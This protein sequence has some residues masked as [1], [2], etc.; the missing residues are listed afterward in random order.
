MINSR[1][2]AAI[3]FVLQAC[4]LSGQT[5]SVNLKYIREFP[6]CFRISEPCSIVTE[7]ARKII[8]DPPCF[9][10]CIYTNTREYLLFLFAPAKYLD[11]LRQCR[12]NQGNIYEAVEMYNRENSV[13]LR[14]ISDR[15]LEMRQSPLIPEYLRYPL[16][17]VLPKCRYESCGD[18]SRGTLE[19]F[20]VYHGSAPE[21]KE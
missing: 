9:R 18:I 12:L 21:T 19:I 11:Q 7:R 3:F 6:E 10:L 5:D 16:P 20:C 17:K 13:P 15:M 8:E 4:L 2:F 14:R 1:I